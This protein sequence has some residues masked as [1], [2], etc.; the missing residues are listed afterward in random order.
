M[1]KNLIQDVT[2]KKNRGSAPTNISP[3]Q[4]NKLP[5]GRKKIPALEEKAA[6]ARLRTQYPIYPKRPVFGWIKNP[7]IWLGVIAILFVGGVIF[8]IGSFFSGASVEI[9]QR[10]ESLPITMKGSAQ[11]SAKTGLPFE[12]IVIKGSETKSIEASDT[13]NVEMKSS[14]KI[15][16]YNNYSS[17]AQKLI[18]N[19]RFEASNGKIYR[20]AS[21]IIVPGMSKKNN[22]TVPGSI[23][24]TVYA[25]QSGVTYNQGL[26]DFTIP[27]FKGDPRYEKF[28]ARSKTELSGGFSG[29]SPVASAKD[30][31]TAK[32]AVESSL[33]VDLL[34]EAVS[35][36]PDGYI[37]YDGATMT[38][39]EDVRDV[40]TD[41]KSVVIREDGTLIGILLKKEELSD[42]LKN[43]LSSAVQNGISFEINSLDKLVFAF[44]NPKL[45]INPE[46]KEISFS[47]IGNTNITYVV[48]K[49]S[50]SKDLAGK[51]KK[52]FQS[53]LT[54]YPS[55]YK[56]RIVSINPFWARYFPDNSSK[57]NIIKSN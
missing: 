32:T 9:T 19:T 56:A 54:R 25:N 30:T 53:I 14:G 11:K 27:G 49:D 3:E 21:E 23:E 5:I 20:I 39:F 47:L 12:I 51:N 38:T 13:K 10:T 40:S 22:E 35:Q 48:N 2:F 4:E 26:T 8:A 41:S 18:K 29:M 7:T 17:A 42:E 6:A 55:V 1:A 43:N 50:L 36:V 34:H 28:Y 31:E 24:T 46:T 33:G 16:I 57:I 37:L 15:I 45:A 44:Q 52:D